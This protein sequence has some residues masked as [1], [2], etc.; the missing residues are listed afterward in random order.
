MRLLRVHRTRSVRIPA[1]GQSDDAYSRPSEGRHRHM[2]PTTNFR[3]AGVFAFLATWALI[4]GVSTAVDEPKADPLVGF[5]AYAEK[6]L[7][8]WKV[9]GMAVA[10]I[11][12]GKVVLARGHGVRTLGEK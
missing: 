4:P 11:K 2:T 10:V 3:V 1:R 9:P 8:D 7:A 5:D 6:A 12:D